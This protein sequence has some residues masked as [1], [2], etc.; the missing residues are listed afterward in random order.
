MP[1]EK[2][3]TILFGNGLGMSLDQNY[4]ALETAIR[5]IYGQMSKQEQSVIRL[6]L[7]DVPLSEDDLEQHHDLATNCE[8]LKNYEPFNLLNE[9]GQ[10]FP[11][12]YQNFI[13]KVA[14][15]FFDYNEDLP[16]YFEGNLSQFI[17][18]CER[19][20][21]ATL[22]YDKLLYSALWR[23]GLFNNG[24]QATLLD[25][26][27]TNSSGFTQDNLIRKYGNDF[28]WFLHIHGS[29]LFFTSTSDSTINKRGIGSLP[30]RFNA[31]M[32]SHNHVVLASTKQKPGI[33]SKSELLLCYWY[34]YTLALSESNLIIL[35][36]YGGGDKHINVPIMNRITEKGEDENLDLY[37]FEW[38]TNET[39]QERK[40]FWAKT[41]LPEDN[42][43]YPFNLFRETNI[44]GVD[45]NNLDNLTPI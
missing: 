12:M 38:K 7:D 14:K 6:G 4:F 15:Y 8:V 32:C 42:R 10:Q 23:Q 45:L 44:L 37:I 2:I 36:G 3:A 43:E 30:P 29:P 40:Q 25:G 19:C 16:H 27:Y 11:E 24:Y 33:I 17:Q 1:D 39:D 41:I 28:G 35:F 34:Y 9:E 20:N 22:N 21:I 13:Y 26:V 31:N 5:N 18:N